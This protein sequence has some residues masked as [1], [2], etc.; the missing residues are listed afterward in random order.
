MKKKLDSK[1]LGKYGLTYYNSLFMV[2]PA[3]VFAFSLGDIDRVS[4]F[5]AFDFNELFNIK[6]L[7]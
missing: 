4:T 7:L 5:L 2:I 6:F 3:F 1:E